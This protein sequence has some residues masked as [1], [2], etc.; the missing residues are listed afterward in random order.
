MLHISRAALAACSLFLLLAVLLIPYAGIQADEALFSAPL[1]PH[2]NKELRLPLLPRGIP[3]MVMSYVGSLKTLLYWPVFRIFGANL[4]T[5]RL[6]AALL[7]A[8][9][10]LFFYKLASLSG[11]TWTAAIG[12]LLLATDPVFLLTNTLDWGPVAL[13]HV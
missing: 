5:L 6:P 4:W 9:T 1:F 11:G 10:V 7:G 8:V 12:A 13:E 3:L 2:I